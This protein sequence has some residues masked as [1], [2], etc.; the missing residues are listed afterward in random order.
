MRSFTGISEIYGMD[1]RNKTNATKLK[2]M[3]GYVPQDLSK[4]YENFTVMENLMTFG[5]HYGIDEDEIFRRAQRIL[6]ALGIENK[7]NELV[8]NLSGGQKRRVSIGIALV[9]NPVICVLD[10]PTSGLDPVVRQN[11][12][13]SLLEINERLG[14]TLIVITHYPE[15]SKFCN[16]IAIFGRGRGLVDFGA[17]QELLTLLPGKGRAIEIDFSQAV[18]E[19]P[20]FLNT[21]GEN[22][23]ILAIKD[24]ERYIVFTDTP[25]LE[26]YN[27]CKDKSSPISNKIK[28]IEH[29]EAQMEH[30][31]RFRFLD[32]SGQNK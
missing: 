4:I 32:T 23:V 6:R 14:T 5:V 20:E 22:T 19:S 27:L 9:H 30:F 18:A 2:S 28:K 13:L 31:F 17:P 7:T 12:W 29:I 1:I 10:E 26:Y 3:Y 15:E 8:K 25:F 24:Y 21:L 16:K 11:L